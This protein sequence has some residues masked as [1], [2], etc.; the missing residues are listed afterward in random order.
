MGHRSSEMTDWQQVLANLGVMGEALHDQRRRLERT[1]A[2]LEHLIALLTSLLTPDQAEA[3]LSH[4]ERAGSV[5][6]GADEALEPIR[7]LAA[8]LRSREGHPAP[9]DAPQKAL[10]RGFH[11]MPELHPLRPA[12]RD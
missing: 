12:D 3:V 5:L 10:C 7:R 8:V 9:P 2:G 11:W 1:F 6:D 4:A